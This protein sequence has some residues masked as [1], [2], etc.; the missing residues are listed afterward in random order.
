[1][2]T[3]KKLENIFKIYNKKDMVLKLNSLRKKNQNDNFRPSH[4]RSTEVDNSS[5]VDND[6]NSSV[7][8]TKLEN[9]QRR[10]NTSLY[11]TRPRPRAFIPEMPEVEA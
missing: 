9:N 8:L 6:Y 11:S 1:M 10:M 4:F 7:Y 5:Y 2:S 3:E